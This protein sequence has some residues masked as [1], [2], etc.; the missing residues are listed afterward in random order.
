MPSNVIHDT[1][2][3]KTEYKRRMHLNHCICQL[4]NYEDQNSHWTA[5]PQTFAIPQGLDIWARVTQSRSLKD[6]EEM[7][8]KDGLEHILA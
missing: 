5:F 8:D 2:A 1:D 4:R 3:G 6:G 7:L